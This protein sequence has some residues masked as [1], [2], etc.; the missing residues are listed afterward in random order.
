[1]SFSSFLTYF[2]VFTPHLPFE[3]WAVIVVLAVALTVFFAVRKRFSVYGCIAL[4]IAVFLGLFLL[5]ALALSRIGA[6]RPWQP[7]FDFSGEYNR[8][9]HGT[10]EHRVLMLFNGAAFVP[11]GFFLSEFL[12][13]AGWAA[14][15]RRFGYAVLGAFGLSLV[16]ECLQ[17]VFRVGIFE[18]T[19]LVLNTLGAA[20]GAA[21][22]MAGRGVVRALSHKAV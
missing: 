22:A 5:D 4:G 2:R 8:L 14:A 10:E 18:V 21:L 9:V 12:S 20:V 16:I 1:M 6:E 11:F 7:G 15:G 13:E 3:H 17:M 19:D